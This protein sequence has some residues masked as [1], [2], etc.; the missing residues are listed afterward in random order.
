MSPDGKQI[1]TASG[2]WQGSQGEVKIWDTGTNRELRTIVVDRQP[3]VHLLEYSP[4]GRYLAA[5]CG[6][7]PNDLEGNPI[8]VWDAATGQEHTVL[9]GH[10]SLV[11]CLAFSHDGR[12]VVTGSE[13]H[14]LKVWDVSI[15]Q[16]LLTLRNR[17]GAVSVA[18]DPQSQYVTAVLPYPFEVRV[19]DGR[20]SEVR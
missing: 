9:R 11:H 10:S 18:F 17:E 7:A 3:V 12:R 13:D 4:D 5:A 1:A 6:L 2:S 19:W 20:G 8:V 15:G 14:T 16:S